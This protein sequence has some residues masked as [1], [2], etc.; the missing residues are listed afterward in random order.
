M[1]ELPI[2]RCLLLT[3]RSSS[4]RRAAAFAALA[5]LP[6]VAA[7]V[8]PAGGSPVRAATAPGFATPTI[9]DPIN[10]Y[11][12][13][14]L[15]QDPAHPD[16]W[17]A[18][19]PWGTGT[20]LSIWNRSADG[21]H[22]FRELHDRPDPLHAGGSVRQPPGGGDTE[23][24]VDHTGKFYGADLGALITQKALVSTD[25]GATI[26]QQ[27]VPR[28]FQ[29][30]QLAGTDRQWFGLWDPPDPAAAHANSAYKGP[31]PVNYMVFLAA[32]AGNCNCGELVASSVPSASGDTSQVGL[33]YGCD[34]SSMG[35]A[36]CPDWPLAQD[37]PVFIDQLTGKVVQAIESAN[38]V[39]AVEVLTP[40]ASGYMASAVEHTVAHLDNA[41]TGALFPV[42]TEDSAR[43]AY[44]IWVERPGGDRG[45]KSWQVWYSWSPPGAD[46]QWNSW[47]TPIRVSH[48][49]SNTAI[50]P[51]AVAGSG[52]NLDVVWYG[53]DSTTKD[54]SDESVP[55][56]AAASW[57]LYMA[58]VSGANSSSPTITQVKA[59][60][61]PM[62]HGSICLAGLDCIKQQGNRNLADFFEISKDAQGAAYIVF[63]NTAND[64]IQQIPVV[65]QPLPEGTADHS[66]AGIVEVVRQI[67]GM[68][69]NGTPISAPSDIG[70]DGITSAA[71]DARYEPIAGT[72]YPGL[73]VRGVSLKAN[74]D[75]LSATIQ[76]TDPTQ[77]AAAAQAI[78]AP[79]VDFIVRWEYKSKLYFAAL[80]VDA[81]GQT[82]TFFDGASQSIDLC[83]VSACDPHLMTYPGPVIAPNTS[84]STTGTV[85]NGDTASGTPGSISID[86]PRA[87][88]GNPADGER[89]D[90]VGAYSLVSLQSFNTP[91][92]N[93]M[94]ENDMVPVEVD[95]ACCFTPLL[96]QHVTSSVLGTGSASASRGSSG[97]TGA[98]PAAAL[99][100]TSSAATA[101]PGVVGGMVAALSGCAALLSRRRPRGRRPTRG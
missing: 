6:A 68:G 14:D 92:L 53:T 43:N 65:Q 42:I 41:T 9:V 87:D 96:G 4:L 73:D 100:N 58:Q 50:M 26:Q 1:Q 90:S 3:M 99:P 95:G 44:V 83:S 61:R 17:Y 78:G 5:A 74:G 16:I 52:G 49:P 35:T 80:E 19:G 76:L 51:W 85:S 66:G 8:A 21:T 70:V 75:K 40:G 55:D 10:L 12:E 98:A 18:S 71:G 30:T 28:V 31:F 67:S 13:P 24:A 81:T 32:V 89:I 39:P 38:G 97:A 93:A 27:S 20:Q 62:H 72:N 2:C 69:L 60:D 33:D 91:L 22:T 45:P 47:S 29:D 84:H 79:F 57:Y 11:G 37:G 94:A 59:Y 36:N 88:V 54:P 46:S 15:R 86:V 77:I 63:D 56:T 64:L 34:P 23:I 7:L 48:A 82:Q 101:R 25:Q